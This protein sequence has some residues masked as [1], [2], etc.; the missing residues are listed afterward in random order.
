ML[1]MI[2][3]KAK[4]PEG[5]IFEAIAKKPTKIGKTATEAT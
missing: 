4:S 1:E 5:E 2:D 3:H